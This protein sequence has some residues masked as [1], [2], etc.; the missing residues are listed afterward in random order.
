M[1]EE[2]PVAI[3][4]APMVDVMVEEGDAVEGDVDDRVAEGEADEPLHQGKM[5]TL[6]RL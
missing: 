1:L 4:V 2:T 3:L 6:N 5:V